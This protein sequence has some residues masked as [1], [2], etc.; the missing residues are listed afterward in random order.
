M[1]HTWKRVEVWDQ[2][3]EPYGRKDWVVRSEE[4]SKLRE[5]IED[6]VVMDPDDRLYKVNAE[7]DAES[8][9]PGN[10]FFYQAIYS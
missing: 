9:D 3:K 2:E 6:C 10:F 7:V 1:D 4:P 8:V 5:N